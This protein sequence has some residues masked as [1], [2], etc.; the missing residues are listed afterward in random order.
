MGLC[1][2]AAAD[3]GTLTQEWLSGGASTSDSLKEQGQAIAE[4]ATFA[5]GAELAAEK[6]AMRAARSACNSF[7]PAADVLLADGTKTDIAQVKVG[8]RVLATDPVS[9]TTK[10]EKVTDVIVTKTDK[11]FTDLTVRTK[12][13]DGT[14]TST[15]HHP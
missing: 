8:D 4:G 12:T 15:Q 13:G 3:A 9:G 6:L 11:A 1:G 5:M 14:I 10:P 7:L 2:A